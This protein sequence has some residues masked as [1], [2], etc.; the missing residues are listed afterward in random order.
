MS[1]SL[2]VVCLQNVKSKVSLI[3]DGWRSRNLHSFEGIIATW[4]TKDWEY[5]YVVLDFDV[6]S[7]SHS[8]AALAESL[9]SVLVR[10]GIDSNLLA[11]TTDNA[12][13]MVTMC[14][15]LSQILN[16]KVIPQ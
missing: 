14:Q 7:G 15:E 8:G 3:V 5:E 4:I 11:I 12:G 16:L 1:A 6:V 10:F 13:N 9:H 2:I